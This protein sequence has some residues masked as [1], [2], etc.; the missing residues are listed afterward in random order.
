MYCR[1]CGNEITPGAV[2]CVGCGLSVG[3]GNRFC[4]NCKA[5]TNPAAELC[6]VCGH[7]LAGVGIGRRSRLAA[8]V[9]GILLGWLGVH[10]FYLGY[11]NIA[12]VQLLLG[13]L[14]LLT[15]LV[16]TLAAAVW[17]IVEGVM[18]LTGQMNEDADGQPL[19]E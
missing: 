7:R 4:Q 3:R 15:C 16:T 6:R 8:G 17:G 12:I 1:N 18:I 19:G 11:T 13:V 10:R 9:L 5:E 2:I 14:G